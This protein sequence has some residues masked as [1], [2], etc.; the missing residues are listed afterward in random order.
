MIIK[1]LPIT[2][3]PVEDQ[4]KQYGDKDP[5][6]EVRGDIA[7][8]SYAVTISADRELELQ[9]EYEDE[10]KIKEE[11]ATSALNANLEDGTTKYLDRMPGEVV[12]KYAYVWQVDNAKCN[13]AVTFNGGTFTINQR[14][15]KVRYIRQQKLTVRRTRILNLML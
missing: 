15:M 14:D 7:T 9:S 13:Y 12:G 4:S 5:C 2:V 6:D 3:T 1:Q 8:F 11:L 10:A